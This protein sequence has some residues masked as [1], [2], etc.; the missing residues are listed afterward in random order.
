MS[1][2]PEALT[3]RW[4]QTKIVTLRLIF[5]FSSVFSTIFE[6]FSKIVTLRLGALY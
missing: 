1:T 2:V 5:E 4:T 3:L 6:N